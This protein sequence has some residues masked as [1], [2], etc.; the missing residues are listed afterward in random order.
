MH[1]VRLVT[2]YVARRGV[3]A[4]ALV[5]GAALDERYDLSVDGARM[6]FSD[7]A[8]LCDHAAEALHDPNFGLHVG[9]SV[10][11]GHLGSEGV[12]LMS[13][14]TVREMVERSTR[15]STLVFDACRNEF[16]ERDDECV[17]YWHSNLPGGA[18][19][20]RLQDEMNL[21]LWITLARW[22]T[23]RP[24][25]ALRWVSFRHP[26]P[27]DVREH[28]AL[29]RCPVQFG[30][31]ATALAFDTRYLEL[32]LPQANV[33]VRRVMDALCERLLAEYGSITDP[34]WLAAC[35]G[36][37][38]R[39]FERGVPSLTSVASAVELGPS[40]LRAYLAMHGLTF[41]GLVDDLRRQLALGYV[42]DPAFKLVEI[43]SLLGFSEQSAFQRAFKRWAGMTPGH[44]RRQGEVE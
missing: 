44:Y 5:A 32:P 8:R 12:S 39:S 36:A 42:R 28:E 15:Y 23:G 9:Q 22:L 4:D 40:Q 1:F 33:A 11:A 24:D 41:R 21:A 3:T 6:A 19:P 14:T 25:L 20:G 34:P 27:A 37:I 2:D 29:F 35:R 30:A 31:E 38:L 43:A 18:S 17:R 13:C 7:F 16:I 26:R 10:K